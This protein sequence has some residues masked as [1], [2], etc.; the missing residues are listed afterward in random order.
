MK[1]LLLT[2]TDLM[3]I[4]FLVP[5]VKYLSEHGF[6]VELACSEVGGRLQELRTV[7]SGIAP[8]HTVRLVRNPF[9]LRNR[10]G[11]SDLKKIIN[12]RSWD[13]IWTNEP[14]MGVMTRVAAK[15]VRKKGTKVVYMVHGFHFYKG[16]P[17]TNWLLYYPVEK[18]CSRLCDMIITINEED[19]QRAKGF[20]AKRTEKIPGVGVNLDCFAP[21]N[22]VRKQWR[23]K[24]ELSP[25]DT[26]LLTVGELTPRKN[27]HVMIKAVKLLQNSNVKLFVCGC[28]KLE[29]QLKNTVKMLKLEEQVKLLG[30]RKD[31]PQLCCA[32]D[33]FVFTSIQEGLP[34]ALLEAMADGKAIVCSNIRGNVD[35]VKD[36]KGGLVVRNDAE[37]VAA[38]LKELIENQRLRE[39]MGA[40]NMKAV[41]KY[42][43]NIITETVCRLINFD[44]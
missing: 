19:Y 26:L 5:H 21:N 44:D 35:L 20:H 27:Q 6:S 14:V 13:V 28:G 18:H 32:A 3:A 36:G 37:S 12:G 4:Q 29:L 30:Y 40:Y 1:R 24:L 38:A 10:K 31:I 34:R 33:A 8:V 23:E 22:D 11:L 9:S 17:L 39:E 16:A 25:N 15:T 7:L 41:L 42:D 43:I 2:C